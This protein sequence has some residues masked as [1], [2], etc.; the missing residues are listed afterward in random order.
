MHLSHI[1]EDLGRNFSLVLFKAILK[2]EYRYVK[3]FE[4]QFVVNHVGE[5]LTKL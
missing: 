2:E 1:K 3:K 5:N 4:G